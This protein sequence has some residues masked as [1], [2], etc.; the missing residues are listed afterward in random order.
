MILFD[1]SHELKV[2]AEEVAQ[3]GRTVSLDLETAAPTG[4]RE[5]ERGQYDVPPD[6]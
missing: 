6:P 2:G 3:R 4:A 1:A 5:A